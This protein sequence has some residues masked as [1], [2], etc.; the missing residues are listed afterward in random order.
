[1][2]SYEIVVDH[3]GGAPVTVYVEVS[4][5]GVPVIYM[6]GGPGDQITPKMRELFDPAKYMLI[7]YDQRGCGRSKPRDQLDKNTTPHLLADVEVIRAHL[8][9]DKMVVSGGSWGT[10]LALLYAEKYPER[11]LGLILRGVF[12][13]DTSDG[14]LRAL[15]PEKFDQLAYLMR[16]KRPGDYFKRLLHTLKRPSRTRTKVI[17]ILGSSFG[18]SVYGKHDFKDSPQDKKTQVLI[19][20]HYEGN[21]FFSPRGTIRNKLARIKHLPVLMVNGRMDVVTPTAIGYELCKRLPHCQL[22]VVE[23]GHTI[24]EPALAAAFKKAAKRMLQLI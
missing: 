22:E 12:D 7:Q 17:D 6:H 21:H 19:G 13:M 9:V 4:G 1:M 20:A 15:Y 3:L 8:G 23:A 10:S 5:R 14:V 18:L 24:H 2:K 16:I 11:V